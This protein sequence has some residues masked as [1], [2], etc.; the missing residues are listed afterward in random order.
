MACDIGQL[1]GSIEDATG[2]PDRPILEYPAVVERIV[3][4]ARSVR[5]RPF[6]LTARTAEEVLIQGTF[7]CAEDA[8]PD[9][10]VSRMMTATRLVDRTASSR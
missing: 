9:R 1:G 8:I 7:S 10:E 4:A 2:D 6:M 3:A 5:D